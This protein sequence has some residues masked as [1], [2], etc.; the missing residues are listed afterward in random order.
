MRYFL[1]ITLSFFCFQAFSQNLQFF[2]EKLN[3]EICN[4][5]FTVD[6]L[7]YFKNSSPDTIRQ[8]MLYPFPQN[9]GLGKVKNIKGKSIFPELTMPLIANFN[10]K[11]AYFRLKIYPFD[12]AVVQIKY[13]HEIKN[14][15]AEYILTSTKVWGKPLEKAD[16]TLKIPIDI[17]I[18]S[19][20]FDADSLLFFKDYLLYKWEFKDF[21]PD[22]NFTVFFSELN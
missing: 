16:F 21:M 17:K 22:K 19:L 7:Y 11:G 18:D 6:G 2:M 1:L 14:Q 15:K 20:S 5:E 10:Q 9:P 3:F 12:T 13:T 8:Y 4:T